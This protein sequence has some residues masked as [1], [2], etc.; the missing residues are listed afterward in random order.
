MEA[1]LPK[2]TLTKNRKW[3]IDQIENI[4][5]FYQKTFLDLFLENGKGDMYS[6]S[7]RKEEEKI[8]F[9]KFFGQIFKDLVGYAG[10]SILRR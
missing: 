6:N 10:V 1:H 5:K 2:E 3:A 9:E 4:W 8:F 7:L